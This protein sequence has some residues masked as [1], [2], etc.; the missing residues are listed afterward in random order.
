MSAGEVYREHEQEFVLG[1]LPCGKCSQTG[2]V[3]GETLVFRD[4]AGRQMP[5][6]S[7]VYC[8]CKYGEALRLSHC[9]TAG[10]QATVTLTHR[11]GVDY[12][13]RRG[14]GS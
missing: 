12:S 4:G 3:E 6:P 2:T 8:S 11:L 13:P 7:Y 1:G 10:K 5:T 14:D 9:G